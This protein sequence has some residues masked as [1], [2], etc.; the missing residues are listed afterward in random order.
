MPTDT[1]L[2]QTIVATCF[3]SSL[4][5][6]A[7]WRRRTG[8]Y[9][10]FQ[11][12]LVVLYFVFLMSFVGGGVAANYDAWEAVA[13][14]ALMWRHLP[15][16]LARHFRRLIGGATERAPQGAPRPAPERPR[17]FLPK[18]RTPATPLLFLPLQDSYQLLKEQDMRETYVEERN[19]G[20]GGWTRRRGFLAPVVGAATAYQ[21]GGSRGAAT[22]L[23]GVF[24]AVG[25]ELFRGIT[26]AAQEVAVISF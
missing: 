9:V 7:M 14:T 23:G 13:R 25:Q 11:S 5:P 12:N 2:L 15:D 17:K 19:G 3:A 8:E 1:I 6:K 22:G 10:G 4:I 16:R 21:T 24:G 20:W 26:L 18:L